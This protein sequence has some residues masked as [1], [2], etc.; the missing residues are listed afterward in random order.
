MKTIY[1]VL[2]HE[3]GWDSLVGV[4]DNIEVLRTELSL[5]N[6]DYLEVANLNKYNVTSVDQYV[7]YKREI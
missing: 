1:I 5:D 6:L 3:M 4:Y 2:N 7:I